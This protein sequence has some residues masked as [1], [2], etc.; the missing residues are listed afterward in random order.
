MTNQP[1]GLKSVGVYI[2]TDTKD[3][4]VEDEYI[5]KITR[6]TNKLPT[7]TMAHHAFNDMY[8]KS[9][10]DGRKVD[11]FIYMN[12]SFADHLYLMNSR[13]VLNR[14]GVDRCLTYN[15][16]QGGNSSL[17][18]CKFAVDH[19]KVDENLNHSIVGACSH[20]EY[21][22]ENR[23]LGEAVL[24]DGAAVAHFEKGHSD[25]QF[26]SFASKTIGKY[27]DIN[28]LAVGGYRHPLIE[29]NIKNGEFVFKVHNKKN[30]R[31]LLSRTAVYSSNLLTQAME[32]VNLTDQDIKLYVLHS[33][34]H[35]LSKQFVNH[36]NLSDSKVLE[37]VT[38]YGYMGSAGLLMALD[39]MMKDNRIDKGSYVA[40]I[41]MGVDGNFSSAIV[42]V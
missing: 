12:D 16:Y 13:S 39:K 32:K 41:P 38:D 3:I 22:S 34:S 18:G 9:S 27:N 24:G 36:R 37:T 28:Y 1:I 7:F 2:P 29:E 33:H 8:E 17:L 4:I 14:V 19:L 6:A 11:Q 31:E 26:I 25:F 35:T 21:H 42:K 15:M 23:R 10:I 40:V 30:Y 5:Q 20:W